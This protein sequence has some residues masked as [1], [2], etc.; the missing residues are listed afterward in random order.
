MMAT[1]ET[2][3]SICGVCVK[4]NFVTLAGTRCLSH[5]KFILRLPTDEERAAAQKVEAEFAIKAAET[6]RTL[7]ELLELSEDEDLIEFVKKLDEERTSAFNSIEEYIGKAAETATEAYDS[8]RNF[9][10]SS[11][12]REWHD[13][14]LN[15]LGM[16]E[17]DVEFLTDAERYSP[18]KLMV[19][20]LRVLAPEMLDKSQ[21]TPKAKR[22]SKKGKR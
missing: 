16:T 22:A 13:E 21:W 7:R 6:V 4:S 1:E 3:D 11:I 10:S 5:D 14:R 17:R 20:R 15:L 19:N 2:A 9:V 18:V 12:P 8:I